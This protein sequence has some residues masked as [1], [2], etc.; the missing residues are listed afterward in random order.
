MAFL[1]KE[2]DTAGR[3][4]SFKEAWIWEEPALGYPSHQNKEVGRGVQSQRSQRVD[5]G[6]RKEI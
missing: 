1:E 6:A 3:E 5:A 2:F 4:L